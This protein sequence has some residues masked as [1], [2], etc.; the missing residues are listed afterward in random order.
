MPFRFSLPRF[1]HQ[2][3]AEPVPPAPGP[4]DTRPPPSPRSDAQPDQET[5]LS[6]WSHLRTLDP[7]SYD[8]IEL[9]KRLVDVEANRHLALGLTG[10]GAGIVIDTIDK[11]GSS[12][13]R[14]PTIVALI[15]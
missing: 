7:T 1:W 12:N 15:D 2:L 10:K 3:R 4:G 8:C 6:Q 13:R 5:I 14:Y 11:V 9:L